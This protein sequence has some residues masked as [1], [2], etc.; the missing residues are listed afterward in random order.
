LYVHSNILALLKFVVCRV[1]V[2]G[3]PCYS[4]EHFYYWNC[5]NIK[6]LLTRHSLVVMCYIAH[7]CCEIYGEELRPG[8]RC[9]TSNTC[10]CT[11]FLKDVEEFGKFLAFNCASA[12]EICAVWGFYAAYN[13]SF[14]R[15]FGDNQ[16]FPSS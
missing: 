4:E 5:C 7:Y 15:M 6:L 11:Y 1:D 16:S 13:F 2:R 14:L 12:Y 3:K 9:G 8:S 10:L